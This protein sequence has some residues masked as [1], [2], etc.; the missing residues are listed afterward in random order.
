MSL[1]RSSRPPNVEDLEATR[2]VEG[3]IKALGHKKRS[4]LRRAAA[5]ALG[6]LGDARAVEPL[7]AALADKSGPA[8]E[9]AAEALNR[10]GGPESE[11][12]LAKYQP[13]CSNCGKTTPEIHA[14]Y[15]S[16]GVVPIGNAVGI[17]PNCHDEFCN[18]H[19]IPGT[20]EFMG[21][22]NKCPDCRVE[23]DFYWDRPP[24]RWGT[25]PE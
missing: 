2:D 22:D 15:R 10:L 17:C 8:R 1:F 6:K 25:A 18:Q 16:R 23:L 9:T 13:V 12:A 19:S 21:G 7:I 4:D 5:E 24:R 3:L 11:R 20:G 14:V